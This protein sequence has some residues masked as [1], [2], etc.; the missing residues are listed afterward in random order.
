MNQ[1]KG[2]SLVMA[3][4]TGIQ[5]KENSR[6]YKNKWKKNLQ[7]KMLRKLFD[8]LF[9][10]IYSVMRTMDTTVLLWVKRSRVNRGGNLISRGI[11]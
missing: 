6:T 1:L 3:K 10:V 4:K 11:F 9:K 7:N 8:S 2:P 5:Q